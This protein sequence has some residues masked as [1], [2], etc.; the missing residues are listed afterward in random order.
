MNR[1][2][3]VDV[4]ALFGRVTAF[5]TRHAVRVVAGAAVLALAGLVLALGLSP[6]AAPGKLADGD[7]APSRA[8]AD[9]HRA[10][11]GEPVV[12]LV[13]GRLSRMLLT[14]DVQQLLG[15]EGCISG[16]L[17]ASAKAPA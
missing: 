9:L 4:G 15:L 1:V 6:S 5:S 2:L 10:F 11:G 7:N 3:G 14:E 13:R 8:T 17:P 12:I 16:N